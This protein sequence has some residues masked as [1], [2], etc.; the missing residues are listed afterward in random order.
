MFTQVAVTGKVELSNAIAAAGATVTFTLN[1]P[2]TDGTILIEPEPVVAT[3]ASD[4]TFS[5]TLNANDDTTTL[6]IG[7]YYNVTVT[8]GQPLSRFKVAIP[9]ADSPTVNLFTLAQLDNPDV[10]IPYVSKFV[11]GSNV[12]LSPPDG[13][14]TV[15]VASTGGGGG[16]ATALPL[17]N[18]P[19]RYDSHSYG[20]V[21]S[22]AN[23]S[24]NGTYIARLNTILTPSTLTQKSNNGN[25]A[26]DVTAVAVNGATPL[27]VPMGVLNGQPGLVIVDLTQNDMMQNGTDAQ[28]LTG[29][30]NSLTSLLWLYMAASRVEQTDSS[31]TYPVGS[32]THA[33]TQV[34]ASG[35]TI[36]FSSSAGAQASIAF[37]GTDCVIL[38][39]GVDNNFAAI[40]GGTSSV[41]I[42]GGSSV[43]TI[44][45]ANACRKSSQTTRF[46]CSIA[47]PLT[48]MSN[49]AHT[50]T[51]TK[52]D[53][54]GT[55]I[56]ID[57]LLTLN[58]NPPTILVVKQCFLDSYTASGSDA[59]V[60]AYNSAIDTVIASVAVDPN[61][62]LTGT[63]SQYFKSRHPNDLGMGLIA[64]A[65]YDTLASLSFRQGQNVLT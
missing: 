24:P 57:A 53:A 42:D 36:D 63:R 34:V 55:N 7:S 9:A 6:P 58:A 32:W 23:C 35:N 61:T 30:T 8:Y 44:N 62:Y 43:A 39:S 26:M 45:H 17:L 38:A 51:V 48:G 31:F 1:A 41:V 56:Q 14:G 15:T 46:V 2:I 33:S 4:G 3:C 28:A 22:P 20:N 64:K 25:W 11:A 40:A 16:S 13:T 27:P 21:Q 29:F 65:I 54:A 52:T 50:I 49:A 5:Q 10:R 19:L 12:T 59:A 60:T 37:T 47:V 18:T